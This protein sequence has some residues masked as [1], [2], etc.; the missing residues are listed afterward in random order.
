MEA[1]LCKD[2]NGDVIKIEG[3]WTSREGLGIENFDMLTLT[4]D[5]ADRSHMNFKLMKF[6]Y[7]YII[8][9]RASRSYR[10]SFTYI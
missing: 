5:S 8:T 3:A 1:M 9:L 4:T 7:I 6:I 2:I 10:L